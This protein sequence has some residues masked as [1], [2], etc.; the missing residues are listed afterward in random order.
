MWQTDLDLGEVHVEITLLNLHSLTTSRNLCTLPIKVNSLQVIAPTTY[1][2][3]TN[4][5]HCR[6]W[7]VKLALNYFLS[8]WQVLP[9]AK[10][11]IITRLITKCGQ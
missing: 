10:S 11:T 4:L 6:T 9:A 5:G 3:N 1:S 2:N 7:F 8:C